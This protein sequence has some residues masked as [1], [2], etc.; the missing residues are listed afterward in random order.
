MTGTIRTLCLIALGLVAL[1]QT[2][3]IA[4]MAGAAGAGAVAGYM[5]Y[6]GLL[7][8]DYRSNLNDSLAGV[9]TALAKQRFVIDRE[10]ADSTSV[11]IQS[12]TADGSTVRVHLDVIPSAVPGEQPVTRVGVRVG[13]S[14]DD[15]LSA[16]L[17]DEMSRLLP[18]ITPLPP[19]P[20]LTP[21]SA[22]SPPPG[23]PGRLAPIPTGQP[24]GSR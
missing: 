6:N 20:P 4:A 10:T 22:S 7:Y 19:P 17:L 2:G 24:S 9:R 16:R 23:D 3:C 14:G 11:T 15:A 8:R 13:F 12:K 5:Y 21:T 18:G 1:V